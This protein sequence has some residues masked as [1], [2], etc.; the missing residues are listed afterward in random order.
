MIELH[1]KGALLHILVKTSAR[2]QSISV[3]EDPPICR[4][5][6][7]AAPIRGRAN[8]EVIKLIA[9]QL[10][11]STTLIKVV[12]GISSPRK[13]LLIEEVTPTELRSALQR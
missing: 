7:K 4:V 6:V 13:T 3:E 10:G 9:K 12:A 5:S 1:A 8:R 11:V 2:T